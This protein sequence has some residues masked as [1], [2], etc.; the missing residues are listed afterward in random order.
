MCLCAQKKKKKV[1][2]LKE[3]KISHIKRKENELKKKEKKKVL[4]IDEMIYLGKK[5][6]GVNFT[7]DIRREGWRRRR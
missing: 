4:S 1:E 7:V 6:S 2:R 3:K 5:R